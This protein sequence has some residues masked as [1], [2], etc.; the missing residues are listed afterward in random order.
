M[1]CAL[2]LCVWHLIRCVQVH[3][4]GN[5]GLGSGAKQLMGADIAKMNDLGPEYCRSGTVFREHL[6]A[7]NAATVQIAGEGNLRKQAELSLGNARRFGLTDSR[8]EKQARLHAELAH[9]MKDFYA[10]LKTKHKGRYSNADRAHFQTLNAIAASKSTSNPDSR[11]VSLEDRAGFLEVNVKHLQQGRKKYERWISGDDEFL[12][13]FRGELRKDRTPELW[14]NFIIKMWQDDRCTRESETMNDE[15][16]N[17][18]LARDAVDNTPVRVRWI[19]KPVHA[20][21][22]I[23]QEAGA[24][25]FPDDF[26][27]GDGV[28]RTFDLTRANG[29]LVRALKPFNC[30][31]LG[32]MLCLCWRHLQWDCIA[33]GLHTWRKNHRPAECKCEQHKSGHELRKV[34]TCPRPEGQDYDCPACL[35]NTCIECKGAQKIPTCD[36]CM[37]V[38]KPVKFMMRQKVKYTLKD[39]KT[40]EKDDFDVAEL[41]IKEFVEHAGE[42][43]SGFKEHHADAKWQAADWALVQKTFPPSTFVSV[44]RGFSRDIYLTL[45]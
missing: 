35:D 19:E 29:K 11:T 8:A 13:V 17:P 33:M 42:C 14:V 30:K 3:F 24:E 39:G 16:K 26:D 12:F 18:A 10:H 5:T 43:F 40:K 28:Q 6:V 22:A 36:H 45:I 25:T 41:S 37:G 23:M 7:L 4:S 38:L 44:T 15:I 2:Y 27:Y 32:R 21:I 31:K 1:Q 34:M 9:G 20:V